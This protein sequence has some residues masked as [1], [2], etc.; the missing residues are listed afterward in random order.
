M[1]RFLAA[2]IL[3]LSSLSASAQS[4]DG[5]YE[6]NLLLTRDGG[7]CGDKAQK[8]QAEVKGKSIRIVSPR[9]DK[10]FE[11][12]IAADG[13]FFASGPARNKSTLEWRGQI[14]AS[15]KSA[16]GSMLLK[17][18]NPCQFLLSLKRI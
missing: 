10:P 7:D 3:V 1:I 13:Q 4:F 15:T 6:G 2:F 17:N 12:E 9:G 8:F 14:L 5:K 11:G 16:L 18:A